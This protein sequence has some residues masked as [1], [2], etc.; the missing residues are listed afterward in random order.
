[1]AAERMRAHRASRASTM[2]RDTNVPGGFGQP[3]YAGE[4]PPPS[5]VKPETRPTPTAP[6]QPPTDR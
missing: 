6:D 1:M 2:E 4:R 3:P 5:D